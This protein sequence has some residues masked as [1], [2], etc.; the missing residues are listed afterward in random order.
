MVTVVPAAVEYTLNPARRAAVS[1]S[2]KLMSYTESP[3]FSS[4]CREHWKVH[5][6][7]EQVTLAESVL[8]KICQFEIVSAFRAVPR[9]L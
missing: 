2:L 9:E 4:L 5:V 8:F 1:P 6:V 3:V 7:T